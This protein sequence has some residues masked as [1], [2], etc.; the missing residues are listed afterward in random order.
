[1]QRELKVHPFQDRFDDPIHLPDFGKII[2][3]VADADQAGR[4]GKEERIGRELL[5][6]VE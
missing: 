6:P 4:F 2:F 1:V 3:D 5:H